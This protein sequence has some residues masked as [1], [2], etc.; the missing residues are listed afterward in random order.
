MKNSSSQAIYVAL[1]IAIAI[2]IL[3][4][5]LEEMA[6]FTADDPRRAFDTQLAE[7]ARAIG[8][9]RKAERLEAAV[10]DD[11]HTSPQEIATIIGACLVLAL[12]GSSMGPMGTVV[13]G[14]IGGVGAYA[15]IEG[16]EERERLAAEKDIVFPDAKPVGPETTLILD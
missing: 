5:Y 11:E 8:E 14:L 10:V 1:A 6:K 7:G 4:K 16:R 15:L 2:I 9:T 12:V 13:G 3:K